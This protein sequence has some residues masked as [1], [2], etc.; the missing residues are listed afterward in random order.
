[1]KMSA[2]EESNK[3]MENN[4][5]LTS[6]PFIKKGS[7]ET[8]GELWV[9]RETE[10][11]TWKNS[12]ENA[13]VG[14]QNRLQYIV[15]DYGMGK[16]ASLFKIMDEYSE[17]RRIYSV[18]FTLKSEGKEQG[19]I[20]FIFRLFQNF[21]FEKLI[22]NRKKA[23]INAALSKIPS[24]SRFS[25][26]R[27]L[28]SFLF[29]SRT[30]TSLL[31]EDE[32]ENNFTEEKAFALKL[33]CGYKLSAK[34]RKI[35]NVYANIDSLDTAKHYLAALLIFMKALGYLAMILL[36]DEFEYLFNMVKKTDQPKY[37][38]LFRSLYDLP[39]ELGISSEDMV[40]IIAFF[41]ISQEGYS[42][43]KNFES[44][45]RDETGTPLAA[46]ARRISGYTILAKMDKKNVELIIKVR[47]SKNRKTGKTEVEPLIPFSPDFVEYIFKISK[48]TPSYVIDY[49]DHVLDAGIT[50]KVKRLDAVFAKKVLKERGFFT[51]AE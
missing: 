49:C 1:M 38:A 4:Y 22:E 35:V 16:T 3:F 47:L 24:N 37:F 28:F 5:F 40:P 45:S 25:D 29:R 33:L 20:D 10:L 12:V 17:N 7:R 8:V 34:E 46:L 27:Q 21:D 36:I 26:A 30:Q 50:R 32:K 31:S 43:L 23:E 51:G 19:G 44:R 6:P 42:Y 13:I 15:G 2:E 41:G 9:D 11:A 48:G 18:Y 39:D 14:H